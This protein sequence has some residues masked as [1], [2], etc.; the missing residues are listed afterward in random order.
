MPVSKACR[1]LSPHAEEA[2]KAP[3]RSPRASCGRAAHPSRR[4]LRAL[5]RMRARLLKE[6]LK[7][8]P[9]YHLFSALTRPAS[10]GL[11]R[12]ATEQPGCRIPAALNG[13]THAVVVFSYW[14]RDARSLTS[15]PGTST[16]QKCN[17]VSGSTLEN[18][19]SYCS[20]KPVIYHREARRS[21]FARTARHMHGAK[22]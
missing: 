7:S 19:L 5:L 14:N 4:T 18:T 8:S 15:E 22:R 21:T 6:T 2:P 3:S 20:N 11:R 13:V 9:A 10:P 16:L 12:S 1:T 17:V